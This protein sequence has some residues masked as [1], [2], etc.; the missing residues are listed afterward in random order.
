MVTAP[1]EI[2]LNGCRYDSG[3]LGKRRE[4]ELKRR[5]RKEMESSRTSITWTDSVHAGN[6]WGN[7]GRA[8]SLYDSLGSTVSEVFAHNLPK[9]VNIDSP[10]GQKTNSSLHAIGRLIR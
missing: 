4:S 8:S 2:C 6:T 5:N 1:Y 7:N 3:L 9:V 10:C